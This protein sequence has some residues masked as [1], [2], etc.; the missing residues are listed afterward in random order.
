MMGIWGRTSDTA[1]VAPLLSEARAT[2]RG[3]ALFRVLRTSSRLH[4]LN[5]CLHKAEPMSSDSYNPTEDMR[6]ATGAQFARR[7]ECDSTDSSEDDEHGN[8]P[9]K[10]P[11]LIARQVS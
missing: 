10:R 7:A 1:G 6:A 2:P 4:D 3:L 5:F 11:R 9:A 8:R